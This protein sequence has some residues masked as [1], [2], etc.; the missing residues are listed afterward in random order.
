MTATLYPNVLNILAYDIYLHT[1][2]RVAG[3]R[4]LKA[5]QAYLTSDIVGPY[6]EENQTERKYY[7]H[8]RVQ[9]EFEPGTCRATTHRNTSQYRFTEDRGHTAATLKGRMNN[10]KIHTKTVHEGLEDEEK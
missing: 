3:K 8:T 10:L 6:P 2:T 5:A 4:Q 1:G 7:S 9:P